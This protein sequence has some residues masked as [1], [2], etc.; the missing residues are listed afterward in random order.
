MKSHRDP[1]SNT[2]VFEIKFIVAES[3]KN[4]EFQKI[5]PSYLRRVSTGSRPSRHQVNLELN[6]FCIEINLK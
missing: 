4:G 2:K 1:E 3:R 6:K 5:I